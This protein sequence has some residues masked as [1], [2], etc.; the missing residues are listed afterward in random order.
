[1]PTNGNL[2]GPRARLLVV[3]CAKYSNPMFSFLSIA[4][5]GILATSGTNKISLVVGT[6]PATPAVAIC[7][8]KG[9][10]PVMAT[11]ENLAT[12]QAIIAAASQTSASIKGFEGT[13]GNFI[14]SSGGVITEYNV[15]TNITN[16]ALCSLQPITPS[17]TSPTIPINDDIIQVN[18]P[19]LFLVVKTAGGNPENNSN[20][21]CHDKKNTK[22]CPVHNSPKK[23]E[24]KP[25][26]II[27]SVGIEGASEKKCKK[28]R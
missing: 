16:N 12:L 26:K 20:K 28:S 1:M 25:Q 21:K 8:S 9:F 6:N 18:A 23:E 17:I 14:L 22:K 19:K 15:N 24:V 3:I 2:H 7:A 4:I 13:A 27:V 5:Q 10:Y 11:L